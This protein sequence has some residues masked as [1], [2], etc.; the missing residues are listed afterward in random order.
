M[1]RAFFL[2]DSKTW[3]FWLSPFESR[4][5]QP[6]P[7]PFDNHSWW[8]W[9]W[10]LPGFWCCTHWNGN[11]KMATQHLQKS[12]P[13]RC[14]HQGNGSLPPQLKSFS[15]ESITRK[16]KKK[17][18]LFQD[19]VMMRCSTGQRVPTSPASFSSISQDACASWKLSQHKF[20][21]WP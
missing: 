14:V 16:K 17:T 15:K 19:E 20:W 7:V 4:R 9:Q 10:Q 3:D 21:Q 13:R 12:A 6:H 2:D 5:L 18:H 11:K 1:F 8:R